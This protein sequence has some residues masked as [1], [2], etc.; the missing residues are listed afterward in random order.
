MP[1]VVCEFLNIFP[2]D[3]PG[4]PPAREIEFSIE[5]LAGTTTI[6][7]APYHMA[8]VELVELKKQIQDLLDKGLIQPSASP[9]GALVFLVKQKDGSQ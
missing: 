5:V 6:S 2:D 4:L 8:P 7:K 1:E 9:L 3:L